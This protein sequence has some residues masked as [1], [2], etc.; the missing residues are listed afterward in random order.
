MLSNSLLW[1]SNTLNLNNKHGSLLH[2][3][4]NTL[5]NKMIVNLPFYTKH[6]LQI[7][8]VWMN[9]TWINSLVTHTNTEW[10]TDFEQQLSHNQA[11][12][13]SRQNSICGINSA[14]I[15][16]PPFQTPRKLRAVE[17]VLQ[18]K[19]GTSVAAL[20]NL[21]TTLAR[22]SIFGCEEMARNSL[23]GCH[24]TGILD[25]ENFP[26]SRH[27]YVHAYLRNLR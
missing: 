20:P 26:I 1:L 25:Q 24:N 16:D 7:S 12:C 18:E 13:R 2:Y 19:G 11:M 22:E 10:C 6:P 4:L 27:W 15:P 9:S 8:L 5:K 21:T 14:T 3:S 23:S 17:E